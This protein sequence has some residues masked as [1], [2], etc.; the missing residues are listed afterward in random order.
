MALPWIAYAQSF[1]QVVLDLAEV[2]G[3]MVHNVAE[4]SKGL[5]WFSTYNGLFRYDGQQTIRLT[6]SI[7]DLGF[8]GNF[9]SV[10]I[11]DRDRVWLPSD[12]NIAL[13]NPVD[14]T[15]HFLPDSLAAYL[16]DTR[17][18]AVNLLDRSEI[19]VCYDNGYVIISEEGGFRLIKDLAAATQRTGLRHAATAVAKWRGRYWLAGAGKL[20]YRAID[21][22]VHDAGI[23][24]LAD[25]SMRVNCL[26]PLDDKLVFDQESQGMYAYDGRGVFRMD[27]PLSELLSDIGFYEMTFNSTYLAVASVGNNLNRSAYYFRL[28][29]L[30]D[31]PYD[32]ING[33][34]PENY[35]NSIQFGQHDVLIGAG[36]MGVGVVYPTLAQINVYNPLSHTG[37]SS[38]RAIHVFPDGTLFCSGYG[39][40][41]LAQHDGKQLAYNSQYV[42]VA[43]PLDDHT[44]LCGSDRQG[45]FLYDKRTNIFSPYTTINADGIPGYVSDYLYS[46]D[47]LGKQMALGTHQGVLL[48]DM[49]TRALGPLC[50]SAGRQVGKNNW[51]RKVEFAG[52]TLWMA[53]NN[54][55]YTFHRGVY[56]RIFPREPQSRY[57]V[58]D[59]QLFPGEGE[60]WVATN[61]NGLFSI[62]YT[63]RATAHFDSQTQLHTDVVF[64]LLSAGNLLFAGTDRGLFVRT[65][66]NFRFLTVA[67]GLASREFNHGSGFYD[68]QSGNVYVGGINGITVLQLDAVNNIPKPSPRLCFGAAVVYN[69]ASR[70]TRHLYHLPY[71]EEARLTLRA[72]EELLSVYP[73]KPFAYR[74]RYMVGYRI[75]GLADDWQRMADGQLVSLIRASPGDYT[76]QVRAEGDKKGAE[77]ISLYIEKEPAW[78]QTLLFKVAVVCLVLAGLWVFFRYRVKAIKSE[79]RLR[80]Q[81]ARDLHD[82]VGGTLTGISI[83]AD[84]MRLSMPDKMAAD[85]V[86][87]AESSR[88]AISAMN[89]M[90][91]SI[92]ARLDNAAGLVSRIRESTNQLLER[93]DMVVKFDV[94]GADK[95]TAIPQTVRQNI[96]LI[97]KEAV[98]NCCK[99]AH[100]TQLEIGLQF[101]HREIRLKIGDNGWGFDTARQADGR[102]LRNMASRAARINAVYTVSSDERG[103]CLALHCC[104]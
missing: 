38:M 89:D 4:D 103:T 93:S 27:G 88:H 34:F 57:G 65:D 48:L 49:Q 59:F 81:I 71:Q 51:V 90:V 19:A 97:A 20:F 67:D 63:G 68:R 17:V 16:T 94:V 8:R 54:G 13:L 31:A 83:R 99:H 96:Y 92:D 102:G 41:V 6:E 85:L 29:A 26:I 42:Y 28:E 7:R 33:L 95:A 69:E 86:K 75:V 53:T 43:Y 104:F 80:N 35:L 23:V 66:S 60:I 74:E 44:L 52:D 1:R 101:A 61:G 15:L 62:D 73:A 21:A 40:T 30:S 82:E 14:W 2:S 24:P 100:A 87:I 37:N 70:Q 22:R 18:T 76:L 56:Q 78:Y 72:N 39:G 64:S 11:D 45:L 10:F 9:H 3:V 91:W 5:I 32:T 84:F 47:R 77:G 98:N 58:Y 46:I 25:C 50:D 55:L 12:D 79:Q 36:S